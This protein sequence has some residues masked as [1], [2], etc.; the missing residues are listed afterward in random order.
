METIKS[1]QIGGSTIQGR[2]E[3]AMSEQHTCGQDLCTAWLLLLSIPGLTVDVSTADHFLTPN[4][5]AYVGTTDLKKDQT[6]VFQFH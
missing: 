2:I 3:L 4:Y 5:I 1:R 6:C